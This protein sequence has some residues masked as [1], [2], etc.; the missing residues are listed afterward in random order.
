[1]GMLKIIIDNFDAFLTVINIIL[2]IL[3]GKGA[4]KSWVYYKKSKH[5]AALTETNKALLEVEKMLSKLPDI[6]EASNKGIKKS[7]GF[8]LV[9]ALKDI[10]R[11]LENSLNSIR[12]NI[13]IEYIKEFNDIK[14]DRKFD[15]QKYISSLQ[16]GKVIVDDSIN[17][18][19]YDLC[20][21]R[22]EQ[23][24]E[25]IKTII[26]ETENELK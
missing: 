4:Y 16:S 22:L 3:T 17:L 13:P 14:S 9:N 2:A 20:H 5:I 21:D 18:S 7:R 15:L 19:D 12:S 24:Q 8:N 11:D 6:L 23:L 26:A 1:M 25:F 10:G